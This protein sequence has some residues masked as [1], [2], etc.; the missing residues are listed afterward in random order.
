MDEKNIY[1]NTIKAT[2]YSSHL[3]LKLL[4]VLVERAELPVSLLE[5]GNKNQTK[6]Y[7]TT[8]LQDKL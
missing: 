4:Q 8:A 3:H 6:Y 5:A 2:T 7:H 1:I